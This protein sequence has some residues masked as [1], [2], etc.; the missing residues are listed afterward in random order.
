MSGIIESFKRGYEG[1]QEYRVAD[2]QVVCSHCGG[3]KFDA[4][5]ALLNTAGMS[6]VGLDWANRNATL[7]ICETCSHIEWFLNDPDAA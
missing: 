6:F 4:G 7:L 1:N 2:K 3:T 5:A